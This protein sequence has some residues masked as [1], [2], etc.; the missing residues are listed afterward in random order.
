MVTLVSLLLTVHEDDGSTSNDPFP[1]LVPGE[2]GH[3]GHKQCRPGPDSENKWHLCIQQCLYC[4]PLSPG[5]WS[6]SHHAELL[7]E[8]IFQPSEHSCPLYQPGVSD[9]LFALHSSAGS[10]QPIKCCHSDIFGKWLVL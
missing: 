9:Q 4:L 6:V 2:H 7:L 1:G 10:T 3:V 8:Y 5:F